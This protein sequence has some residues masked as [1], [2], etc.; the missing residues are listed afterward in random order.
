MSVIE[1]LEKSLKSAQLVQQGLLPKKRHFDRLFSDYFVIYEPKEM[2]SG[3]FYWIGKK[4]D[5]RY[6]VVGDCTGHGISASLTAVLALNLLEYIIMNK[7]IKRP[8]K[9][10]EELDQRFIE[11]FKATDGDH[12]DNPWIDI[13]II[14]IDDHSNKMFFSAANRKIIHASEG[15]NFTLKKAIGYPIG[16]WQFYKN[17]TF[18]SVEIEYK[19]GDKIYMGSDGF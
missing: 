8:N 2:I 15:E 19:K 13:A 12:F 17:R 16:G 18:E 1:E 7:G 11:S 14:S 6:L 5:H 10:L 3:D 4:H 9:I